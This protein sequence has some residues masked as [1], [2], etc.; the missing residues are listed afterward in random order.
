MKPAG[1]ATARTVVGI[2]PRPS[3]GRVRIWFGGDAEATFHRAARCGDGF[4]PINSPPADTAPQAFDELRALTRA[5]GRDP[6][7][8]GLEVWVGTQRLREFHVQA[9]RRYAPQ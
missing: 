8:M 2:D 1:A 9:V 5:A 6:A 7:A 3:S 4:M